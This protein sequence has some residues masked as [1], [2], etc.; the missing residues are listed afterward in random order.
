MIP[1]TILIADDSDIIRKQ[2][3]SLATR[4]CPGCAIHETTTVRETVRVL[5]SIDPDFV[6]LDL[7]FPDG[8]GLSVLEWLNVRHAATV[9]PES[10]AKIPVTYVFTNHPDEP[11]RVRC[12]QLGATDFF[13]KSF[14]FERLVDVL[15]IAARP[16]SNPDATASETEPERGGV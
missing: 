4:A 16:G 9:T 8:T 7:S 3:T 11:N 15:Q 12:A 2:I 1:V 14:D 13:D 5:E 6:V 10:N